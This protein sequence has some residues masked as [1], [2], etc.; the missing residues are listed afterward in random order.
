[1]SE[2]QHGAFTGE[3]SC[4]SLSELNIEFCI[5]GHS[6]RRQLFNETNNDVSLK[7]SRVIE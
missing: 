2:H 5:L 7:S 3:I 6:E 4:K 1:M